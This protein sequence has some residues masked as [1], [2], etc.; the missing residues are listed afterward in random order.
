MTNV[1]NGRSVEVKVEDRGPY[2]RNR[3]IDLSP[4]TAQELGMKEQ[5]T[6]QVVVTPVQV[7]DQDERYAQR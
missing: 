2:A 1:E 6:A 3:V 5:G 4:R 7:P